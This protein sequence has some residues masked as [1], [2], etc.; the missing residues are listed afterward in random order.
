MK[1]KTGELIGKALDYAV[2]K[3]VCDDVRCNIKGFDVVEA[4]WCGRWYPWSPSDSWTQCGPL[5]DEHIEA[6]MTSKTDKVAVPKNGTLCMSGECFMIS[7]CRTIV[8]N[9]LGDEV[10]IPE[11]LLK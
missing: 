2:G 5:I 10:E 6:F 3:A 4:K 1:V 8:V 11:E 7:S 9:A